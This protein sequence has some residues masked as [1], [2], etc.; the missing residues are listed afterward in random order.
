MLDGG[1]VRLNEW[2]IKVFM[3]IKF[4]VSYLFGKIGLI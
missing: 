1:I 3:S 4:Y 2:I